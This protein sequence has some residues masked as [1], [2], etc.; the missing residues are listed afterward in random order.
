MRGV[1]VASWHFTQVHIGEVTRPLLLTGRFRDKLR[2]D[3]TMAFVG[4]ETY[5]T[6]S[7]VEVL[8]TCT[9]QT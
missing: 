3:V 7:A 2:I 6:I 4:N 9:E 8:E 1:T 5:G